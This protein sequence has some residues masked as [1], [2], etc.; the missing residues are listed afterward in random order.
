MARRQCYAKA[1]CFIS[2]T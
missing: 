2:A 1:T